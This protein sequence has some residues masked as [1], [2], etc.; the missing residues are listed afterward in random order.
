MT[1][2]IM[3]ETFKEKTRKG[4]VIV[5]FWAEWCGPCKRLAP[6]FDELGKE[7]KGKVAFYKV[8][9]D[10]NGELAQGL[11]VM[12]IPCLIVFKDGAEVDRIV[13]A[14]SKEQLRTKI[15]AATQ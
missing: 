12:G 6:I 3:Q 13:G 8:N 11:G 5:D 7:Y 1:E 14:M 4:F 15:D 10:E 2:A 9:V